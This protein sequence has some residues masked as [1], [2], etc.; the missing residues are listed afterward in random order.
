MQRES[1]VAKPE[2][3]WARDH[4]TAPDHPLSDHDTPNPATA[5]FDTADW[6][7]SLFRSDRVCPLPNDRATRRRA[8]FTDWA[9]L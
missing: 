9:D 5:V 3:R 2:T 4:D 6:P 1:P 8:P 7:D